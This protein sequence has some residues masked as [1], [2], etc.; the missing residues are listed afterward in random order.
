MSAAL[1]RRLAV[2]GTLLL[3]GCTSLPWPPAEPTPAPVDIAALQAQHRYVS[4]LAALE[5][6]LSYDPL[7]QARR[8]QLLSAA[9]AYQQQL[10]ADVDALARQHKFSEAQAL[11]DVA[12]PELPNTPE[13]EQFRA[14]FDG[15]RDRYVARKLGQLTELKRQS[16]LREQ[17]L[18]RSLDGLGDA[19]LRAAEQRNSADAAYFG[20]LFA[21]AGERALSEGRYA[22]AA[23]W[24]TDA[25]QLLP[26]ERTQRQLE[27][28]Q[29]ALA[30]DRQRVQ[31][32]RN[33]EREQRF[34]QLIDQARGAMQQRRYLEARSQLNA[35]EQ[36]GTHGD[37]IAQLRQRLELAISGFITE[38]IQAGDRY[39]A[40]GSIEK[41]LQSWRRAAALS[42]SQELAERIEKAERFMERYQELKPSGGSTPQRGLSRPAPPLQ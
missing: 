42:P 13:L 18:Y 7:Y 21:A 6:Q 14:R 27:S 5:R 3:A 34:Q 38:Q 35:A 15:E 23:R 20:E 1:L 22:E 30:S 24:L 25:N 2:V 32:Q 16:L 31:A 10:F 8:E 36:L 37:T 40:N 9:Q 28:A 12:A 4:A 11:L 29:Q 26:S 41:A 39:Y 17:A 19:A 33:V